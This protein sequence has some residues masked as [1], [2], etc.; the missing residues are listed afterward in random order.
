MDIGPQVVDG[1]FKELSIDEKWSVR[2]PWGFT[3]WSGPLRQ[4]VWAE[5]PFE[6]KGLNIVRLHAR[7]DLIREFRGKKLERDRLAKWMANSTTSG[8]VRDPGDP[9][10][11][12]Q[13]SSMFGHEDSVQWVSK[14]FEFVVLSQNIEALTTCDNLALILE[15]EADLSQHPISGTR[16][17][18]DEMTG[19]VG[20]VVEP[21]G[22][23]P[24]RYAG[25]EMASLTDFFR[26][27]F[28]VLTKGDE[29]MVTTEFPFLGRTS[30][31]RF[32]AM[33]PHPALGCGLLV[34]LGLPGRWEK[35]GET[36]LTL[37]EQELKVF[38]GAHFLG[39][40]C[41]GPKGTISYV[42]FLPNVIYS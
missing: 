29:V 41:L 1:I 31:A 6:D 4:R 32:V 34:T 33:D 3:W 39:S 21:Q 15:A 23:L 10:R 28:A 38:N 19:F 18:P 42:S 12:Q 27:S 25:P 8:I 36:A 22:C 37:N 7:T 30:L 24:S 9:T 5:E 11:L 17:E 2:E 14:L 13:A 35:P 26:E 16:D 20:L 40:W